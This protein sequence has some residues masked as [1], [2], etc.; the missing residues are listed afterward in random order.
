MKTIGC[1]I[2]VGLPDICADLLS[3]ALRLRKIKDPGEPTVFRQT[4]EELFRSFDESARE[5]RIPEADAAL[6]KYA[7]AASI[8]ELVLNS[9]WPLK[10]EWADRPLQLQYF[11]DLAAGEELYNKLELLRRSQD[12]KKVDVLEVYYL[13]LALGFKGKYGD[14]DG[15]A[16]LKALSEE[17]SKEITNA[18]AGGGQQL[19]PK[20]AE[21][22]EAPRLTKRFPLWVLAV[23]GVTILFI[24]YTI[25]FSV[26]SGETNLA[27]EALK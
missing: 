3:F 8:D 23:G 27:L 20:A 11:N 5:A 18:R 19:S 12:P 26:L 22:Q 4:V 16:A 24:L 10:P 6:A 21:R 2:L 14:I 15:V 25:L 13:C 17:L 7:L 1:P 9:S